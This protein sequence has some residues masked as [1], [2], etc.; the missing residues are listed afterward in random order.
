VDLSLLVYLLVHGLPFMAATPGLAYWRS[1]QLNQAAY[2]ITKCVPG[3]GAFG[4]GVQY[5]M[6]AYGVEPTVSTAAFTAVGVWSGFVTL[7]LLVLGVAA[8]QLSG[9]AA[10]SYLWPAVGLVALAVAILAFGLFVRSEDA[11]RRIGSAV[12]CT[13]PSRSRQK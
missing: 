4:L 12:A 2:V 3:G 1:Q 11:A 7:G 9:H 5:E 6:L 13:H 10:S 8:I